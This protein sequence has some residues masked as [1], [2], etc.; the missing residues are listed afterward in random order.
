M[1]TKFK[2]II[3]DNKNIIPTMEWIRFDNDE[4][5]KRTSDVVTSLNSDDEKI[6]QQMKIFIDACYE[7]EFDKYKIRP[8]IA[9]AAPQM[10]LNKRIIYIHFSE[11]RIEHQ[12]LLVNP[13]II[14][15]SE[16]ISFVHNGEGCLS[17]PE[18]VVCNIPRNYKIIVKAFDLIKNE[19][20]EIVA[21]ELLS[22]CLQHEIDH[23]NGLLYTDRINKNK[24]KF[25]DSKWFKIA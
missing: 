17:V 4:C 21:S 12:Y 19:Y 24:P 7:N 16:A 25:I 15:V 23:L 2:K 22:I 10:G 9:I 3:I 11:N 18:D 20:I 14:S 1:E 8:G 5:L 6:I 13:E